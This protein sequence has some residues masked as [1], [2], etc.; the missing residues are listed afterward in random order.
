MG[1]RLQFVHWIT[2]QRYNGWI[3]T[4]DVWGNSGVGACRLLKQDGRQDAR[5]PHRQ[6]VCATWSF[7]NL[8]IGARLHVICARLQLLYAHLFQEPAVIDLLRG[9]H[10]K[11]L[12]ELTVPI[13]SFHAHERAARLV[14]PEQNVGVLGLP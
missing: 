14:D 1:S 4:Y 8:Q 5:P 7:L 9:D 13:V 10:L 2:Y 6:D 11:P 3:N 12:R